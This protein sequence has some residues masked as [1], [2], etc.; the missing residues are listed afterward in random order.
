MLGGWAGP[1]SV[2]L[3]VIGRPP[4]MLAYNSA[5]CRRHVSASVNRQYAVEAAV[6]NY[7]Y[8]LHLIPVHTALTNEGTAR[9]S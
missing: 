3:A 6:M 4:K 1:T 2:T 9:L 5:R 8:L 7:N